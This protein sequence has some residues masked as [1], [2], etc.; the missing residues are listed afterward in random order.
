MIGRLILFE[1]RYHLARASTYIYFGV[2]FAI[3]F[4]EMTLPEGGGRQL[5]DNPSALANL[6]AGHS[7]FGVL[8]VSAICGMA[9]CRDFELDVHALLFTTRVRRRDYLAGRWLGSLLVSALV[10]V[11]IPAGLLAGNWMPWVDR[12]YRMPFAGWSYLQPYLTIVLPTVFAA[13]TLF[14]AIGA[15]TR[16][17]VVVY[18]QGALFLGIYLLTDVLLPNN[19][20]DYWPALFDPFGLATVAQATKYWTI[21]ET[22]SQ[23]V[24]LAGVLLANRL[25]WCGVGA[26]AAVAV[27]SFFPFST[28]ALMARRRRPARSPVS[29]ATPAPPSAGRPPVVLPQFGWMTTIR[30]LASLTWM[31]VRTIVTDL[32]FLSLLVIVVVMQLGGAWGPPRVAGT[33]VLPVTYLMTGGFGLLLSIVV[34][35]IYAGELTWKDRQIGFGQVH[36][37]LPVPG[38]VG[39]AARLGALAAVQAAFLAVDMLA[40]IATQVSQGYYRFEL[41][42]YF[43]EIFV[44]Q[45]SFLL[46]YAVLALFVHTVS[47]NKFI[48]HAVVIAIFLSPTAVLEPLADR[49]HVEFPLKLYAYGGMPTYTYSDLNGYGPYVRPLAW[50]TLYWGLW[51]ALLGVAAVLLARRGTDTGVRRRLR[52]ARDRVRGPVLAAVALLVAGAGGSGGWI[53]YNARVLNDYVPGW[54]ENDRSASYEREYKQFETLPQPKVTDVRVRLELYPS[55]GVFTATGEITL[56][57]KTD[58]PIQ[59]IHLSGDDRLRE[60]SFGRA[61]RRS[62]VDEETDYA[63]YELE[64]PLRPGE[65]VTLSF[66][67]AHDYPGFSDDGEPTDVVANGTFLNSQFIPAIGYQRNREIENEGERR[68]RG[69]GEREELPPPDA[70]GARQRLRYVP[71]ADWVSYRAVIGTE[72]DQIALTP[73]Y[74][75][76]EWIENGRRYFEYDFGATPG[77]KFFSYLSGRYEV[78]REM[79]NDVSIEVYHDP[80]H[81]YNVDRMIAATRAGL[82]YFSEQFGPY[83][84]RQ[85]RVVEVP[86]Y[87]PDAQSFAN[88][89]SYSEGL[90]FI[91][92]Q[93]GEDE[94]DHPFYVTLHELAHQWWGHQVVG[95]AA[96]GATVLSES[97]AEYSMLIVP[98]LLAG[99]D[100]VRLYLKRELDLYLRGRASEQRREPTLARSTANYVTYR[101]GSLALHALKDH[102]GDGVVNTALRGLIDRYGLTKSPPFPITDDLI[103]GLRAV[104]PDD[105][106]YLI[107]DFFE[108]ITLYDNR[109]AAATWR[110]REDG[111]YVVTLTVQSGKVR[112]DDQGRETPTPMNDLVDIGVFAGRGRQ[113]RELYLR[114]HRLTGGEAAFEIVVDEEPTRAGIDPYNKL[115]DRVSDDNVVAVVAEGPG[116]RR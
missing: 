96:Q 13:G 103:A 21:V 4:I 94:V 42:L 11:S 76:H 105:L 80:D 50:F 78:R 32:V 45:F 7:A 39:F 106:Q 111:K 81:A 101:K 2:W 63:V 88:T 43:T 115:I 86:R 82:E 93:A 67:A 26:L 29:M 56:L 97:L 33:P 113:E 41:G 6:T 85:F 44:L 65:T 116:R 69:L 16:R 87:F 72:P 71:D 10:L 79:W 90:G 55:R 57:N 15:L 60:V 23:L 8:V 24:P 68:R 46:L 92:R 58:V 64:E 37:A 31:R 51:A 109:A 9:I 83:Q 73:G 62:L 25:L 30:Q 98:N 17:V 47:P 110:L 20:D 28:E 114:K 112:A 36:D 49:L 100:T 22:N 1:V 70:P 54:E 59:S 91:A 102:L 99:P 48:G 12:T 38:W 5:V 75:V 53:Y 27:F 14:F 104:T 34:T 40:G 18:L 66:S 74:L 77:L 89:V 3:A 35:T 107:T 61:S 84:F 19:I 108:T 95:A 52:Q